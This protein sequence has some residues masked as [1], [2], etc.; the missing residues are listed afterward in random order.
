MRR[1]LTPYFVKGHGIYVPSINK[2]LSLTDAFDGEMADFDAAVEAGAP[3]RSEWIAIMEHKKEINEL[4]MENNGNPLKNDWYWSSSIV[5]ATYAWLACL[6][7]RN[8]NASYREGAKFLVRTV[9]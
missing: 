9:K 4:L 3:T 5:D 8:I 2:T 1:D 6:K 7:N